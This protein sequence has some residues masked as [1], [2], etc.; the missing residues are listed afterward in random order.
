MNCRLGLAVAHLALNFGEILICI[1][2]KTVSN[3][4]I[5]RADHLHVQPPVLNA[6]RMRPDPC[7]R[8]GRQLGSNCFDGV[9]RCFR[10]LWRGIGDPLLKCRLAVLQLEHFRPVDRH[11]RLDFSSLFKVARRHSRRIVAL[12]H[13]VGAVNAINRA[14]DKLQVTILHL[15]TRAGSGFSSRPSPAFSLRA[16][17]PLLFKLNF[18]GFNADIR[19]DLITCFRLRRFSL[20]RGVTDDDFFFY[21]NFFVCH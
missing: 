14:D 2:L 5:V 20:F 4:N 17:Q 6:L 13:V 3:R 12:Q 16:G 21:L 1:G 11:L 7:C 8:A 9:Q 15:R 18:Q 10:L 19:R